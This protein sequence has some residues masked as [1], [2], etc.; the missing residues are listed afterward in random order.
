LFGTFAVFSIVGMKLVEQ[1]RARLMGSDWAKLTAHTALIPLAALLTGK[2]QPKSLPSLPRLAIAISVWAG[3]FYLHEGVI[4][5]I[6]N[7]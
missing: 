5:V 2:W 6:P 3:L 1:R 4:G 7:P